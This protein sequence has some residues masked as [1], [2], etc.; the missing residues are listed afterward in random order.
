MD[1]IYNREF[2]RSIYKETGL[3]VKVGVAS[4]DFGRLNI[5]DE[6]NWKCALSVHQH[7]DV[8]GHTHTDI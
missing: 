8:H 1:M 7:K 6:I 3:C 5:L 4:Y 2:I